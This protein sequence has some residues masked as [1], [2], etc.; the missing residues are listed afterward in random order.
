MKLTM[1]RWF[2]G[3]LSGKC[4][5][6]FYSLYSSSHGTFTMTLL[7]V[8]IQLMLTFYFLFTGNWN[9]RGIT[10]ITWQHVGQLHLVNIPS[11]NK[12]CNMIPPWCSR[13]PV[14]CHGSCYIWNE[15]VDAVPTTGTNYYYQYWCSHAQDTMQWDHNNILFNNPPCN[16]IYFGLLKQV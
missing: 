1:A 5:P 6:T 14:C 15:C 7:L 9:N 8:Q 13:L 12:Y 3:L 2:T 16:H 4:T 11:S 10:A